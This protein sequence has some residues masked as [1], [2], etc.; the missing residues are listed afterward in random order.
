MSSLITLIRSLFSE[1]SKTSTKLVEN[2]SDEEVLAI[3]HTYV[4]YDSTDIRHPLNPLHLKC[5]SGFGTAMMCLT[6]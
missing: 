6:Y 1:K 3:S 2:T 5:D 4:N